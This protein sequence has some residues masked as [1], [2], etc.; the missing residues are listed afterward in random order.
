MSFKE[1]YN[2]S[3]TRG[4]ILFLLLLSVKLGS[5][6]KQFDFEKYMQNLVL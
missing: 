3:Q 6:L 5:K 1:E 2:D 4:K